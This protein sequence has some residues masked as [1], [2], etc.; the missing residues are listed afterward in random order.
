MANVAGLTK[1]LKDVRGN[2]TSVVLRQGK[3]KAVSINTITADFGLG[4][5][6]NLIIPAWYAPKVDDTVWA[7]FMGEDIFI[8]GGKSGEVDVVGADTGSYTGD[9][10]ASRDVS[11][12]FGPSAVHVTRQ[13]APPTGQAGVGYANDGTRGYYF[14]N[15]YDPLTENTFAVMTHST[16]LVVLANGFRVPTALNLNTVAY[17]YTA[18]R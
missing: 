16:S 8:L 13:S 5:I 4:W 18:F 15:E 11:L 1:V 2:E 10:A 12:G 9:G 6:D 7:L 3:V 14:Q 17:S